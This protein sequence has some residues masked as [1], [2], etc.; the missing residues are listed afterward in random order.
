MKNI[1]I[2]SMLI[3]S[4]LLNA[5]IDIFVL[6]GQSNSLG[7]IKDGEPLALAPEK[8]DKKIMFFWQNRDPRSNIV[9]TSKGKIQTLQVQ[10]FDN[11]SKDGNWGLEMFC[12]RELYKKTHRKMMFIKASRGGGGNY[13][14]LK[15][16]D[17]DHMYQ[18]VIETVKAATGEL[19][20]KKIK[21]KIRGLLYLQGESDGTHTPLA[22]ERAQKLLKNLRK[23]LPSAKGMKMFIGEIAGNNINQDKTREL[24]KKLAENN[25]DFFFIPTADLRKSSL[26]RDRLHFNNEA[27]K[28]IGKRFASTIYKALK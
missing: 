8:I 9:S 19:S 14:W 4:S 12:A 11:D 16:S 23:E 5:E 22:A 20:K 13:L 7:I 6:T 27:K 1:V 25:S 10:M 18:S 26:Y 28:E 2:I 21:F 15:N 24:H 17:D 3:L